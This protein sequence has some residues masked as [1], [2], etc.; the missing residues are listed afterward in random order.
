MTSDGGPESEQFDFA[1]DDF[2]DYFTQVIE[3]VVENEEFILKFFSD[4]RNH[5]AKGDEIQ[6]FMNSFFDSNQYAYIFLSMC[7]MNDGRDYLQGFSSEVDSELVEQAVEIWDSIEWASECAIAYNMATQDQEYWTSKSL[8]FINNPENETLATIKMS[9]GVDTFMD[10]TVPLDVLI[11][12]SVARL[13]YTNNWWSDQ[14][15]DQ[16]PRLHEQ[17]IDRIKHLPD[18]LR[19]IAKDLEDNLERY[20]KINSSMEE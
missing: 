13:E 9:F 16:L 7:T 6:P 10:A 8:S 3:D 15:S 1:S 11:E 18:R 12:D 5:N 17:D 4:M 2:Q 20:R 19:T 14:E